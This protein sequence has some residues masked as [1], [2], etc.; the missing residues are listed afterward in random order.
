MERSADSV[1][2]R[3]DVLYRIHYPGVRVDSFPETGFA[4]RDRTRRFNN[5]DPNEFA[6]AIAHQFTWGYRGPLPFISL[7]SDLVHA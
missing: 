4:A 3:P 7:F 1:H 2:D 5:G 6:Q